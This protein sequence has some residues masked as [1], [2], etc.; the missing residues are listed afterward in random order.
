VSTKSSLLQLERSQKRILE[1]VENNAEL[2]KL[3]KETEPLKQKLRQLE[4]EIEKNPNVELLNEIISTA[5]REK[6]SILEFKTS[7][8]GIG[9]DMKQVIR[10]IAK[11]IAT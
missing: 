3:L 7:I 1:L 11:I 6:E 5:K 9:I 10:I 2:N 8:F 4:Q